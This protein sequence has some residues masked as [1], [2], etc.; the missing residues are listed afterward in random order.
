MKGLG[1]ATDLLLWFLSYKR[2]GATKKTLCSTVWLKKKRAVKRGRGRGWGGTLFPVEP[3]LTTE[4]KVK[5]EG[6]KHKLVDEARSFGGW[7][8]IFV[9]REITPAVKFFCRKGRVARGLGEI[10]TLQTGP[11]YPYLKKTL[12]VPLNWGF[13]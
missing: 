9:R 12:K 4:T 7:G 5:V 1:G 2:G 8:E 10:A 13:L 6:C 3:T 11:S